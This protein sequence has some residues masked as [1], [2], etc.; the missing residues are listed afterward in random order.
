MA[1]L[2]TGTDVLAA[3]N[4]RAL[5]GK[6]VGLITNHTGLAADGRPLIDLLHYDSDVRLKV[7]FGP[8]HGIRGEHDAKVGDTQ[9]AKTGL[10]VYSL[11]GETMRPKPAQL[12]DLDALVFDIQDIG[13]RFYTYISTLGNCM[14]EAA[15]AGLSFYVLDRPNPINGVDVE[16]PMADPDKLSFTAWH[17][18]PVRH[19]LTVGE[20]AGLFN[21]ERDIKLDL[22]VIR[23]EG[24]RRRDWWDATG[25]TWTNPSPNMRSLTQATLYPGIGLLEFTNLSVGRGTDSPFEVIGAPWLDG[26]QL[27][28]ELNGAGLG[29]VRFVP[30]RYQPRA[31]VFAGVLCSGINIIIT[32]R[33]HFSP[34]RAGLTIAV[35][36]R[37]LFP[38]L[39]MPERYERLL[40]NRR[41][42]EAV[43]AGASVRDLVETWRPALESWKKNRSKHLLYPL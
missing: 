39:W 8:E 42:H 2:K 5:N 16:G 1:L 26:R 36:L 15:K 33:D 12:R 38:D 3:D 23:C 14:E 18:I 40:A 22:K 31:S 35:T 19:G 32:E 43:V 21:T 17:P 11:Y 25:L 13:C 41:I 9:D 34:L 4:F 29:G 28:A 7:L 6:R 10:P 20:L 27:A 24:W 30:I 37:M